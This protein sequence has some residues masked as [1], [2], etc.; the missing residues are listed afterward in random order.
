[1]SAGRRREMQARCL[2]LG[3]LAKGMAAQAAD[4][5]AQRLK[6]FEGMIVGGSWMKAQHLELMPAESATLLDKGEDLMLARE[7][8]LDQRLKSHPFRELPSAGVG[9]P[10]PVDGGRQAHRHTEGQ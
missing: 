3:H 9:K 10:R 2:I 4:M 6:A 1:M 7:A 8:E 5:A